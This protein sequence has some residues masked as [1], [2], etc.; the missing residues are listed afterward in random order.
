MIE[1]P[2]SPYERNQME[3]IVAIFLIVVIWR[4]SKARGE[5]SQ[6][7]EPTHTHAPGA[8]PTFWQQRTTYATP[9]PRI[10]EEVPQPFDYQADWWQVYS[11][12][13]RSEKGWRCEACELSLYGH[14]HLLHTH[15]VC[16][17]LQN[18]PQ[19]L[20]ALCIGCHS[21]Q[22]GTKHRNL[23]NTG[24]YQHFIAVYGKK[25]KMLHHEHQI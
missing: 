6:K 1:V 8:A 23:K 2:G 17:T 16:G 22:P 21:E 24:D 3:I 7:S 18:E 19:D 11:L 15:H 4:I 20:M 10:P 12:W 13:F 25:W 14:K 9:P 5:K